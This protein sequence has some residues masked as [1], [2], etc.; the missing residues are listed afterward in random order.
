MFSGINTPTRAAWIPL[1]ARTKKMLFGHE[2]EGALFAVNT[3]PV[4]ARCT[5][6][7]GPPAIA[8]AEGAAASPGA[9]SGW[10]PSPDAESDSP[11]ASCNQ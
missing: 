5:P 8:R 4:P 1:F 7:G 2:V 11:H 9:S 6:S 3:P 10:D